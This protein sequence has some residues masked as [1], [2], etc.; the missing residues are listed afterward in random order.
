MK[1]TFSTALIFSIVLST[2]FM[3]TTQVKATTSATHYPWTMFHHDLKHTGFSL[4]PAPNT[5]DILWTFETGDRIVSSPAI[6][7]G[8]V[9]I[10]SMDN[11]IYAL[12]Q[13]S[14]TLIWSSPL[15]GS[16]LFGSPAVDGNKVFITAGDEVFALNEN[17]G[18]IIWRR[19]LGGSAEASSPAVADGMLFVGSST[20][21]PMGYV[22]ALDVN[23]GS[24]VWSHSDKTGVWSSPAVSNGMVFVSSMRFSVHD[25]PGKVFAL[26]QFTGELVWSTEIGDGAFVSSPAV[27]D[28]KIFVGGLGVVGGEPTEGYV[29]ALDEYIGSILWQ[30]Q[31]GAQVYSSP[32]V[33]YSKVFV[34]CY[35]GKVYAFDEMNG[36]IVWTFQ[37]GDRIEASSPAVADGKVFIGSDDDNLYALD[38]STGA[39]IWNYTTGH[40]VGSSPAVADGVVYVGSLDGKVYTFGHPAAYLGQYTITA[41]AYPEEADD[42][43]FPDSSKR[44]TIRIAEKDGSIIKVDVKTPFYKAMRMNGGGLVNENPQGYNHLVKWTTGGKKF[45]EIDKVEGSQGRELIPYQSVAIGSSGQL[46]YG[47]KG[48]FAI[49]GTGEKYEFSAD[50]TCPAAKRKNL[51]DLWL[52]VGKEAYDKAWNW[53][54]KNADLYKYS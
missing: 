1:K 50:D 15:D 25:I 31:I 33:A 34:G 46:Q 42:K 30:R 53:G 37:T 45:E 32:A 28:G 17:T 47:D 36:N 16:I 2:F 29:Y 26:N 10:G 39:K 24:V 11:K 14:G 54:K 52:G 19:N 40:W 6:A 9:F 12:D 3:L 48:Y 22:S 23:T 20:D 7:D 13:L 44:T 4:S 41:Y 8:K 35:D 49:I 18:D 38:A 21:E 27:V 5:N 51:V 43:Y